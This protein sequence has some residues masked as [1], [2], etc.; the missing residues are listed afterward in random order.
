MKTYDAAETIQATFMDNARE[1]VD[2]FLKDGSGQK[3]WSAA[4]LMVA[5][6]ENALVVNDP[7]I[8]VR[9]MRNA[10]PIRVTCTR[11][12]FALRWTRIAALP[13]RSKI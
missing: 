11:I 3:L 2:S 7:E 5:N 13:D 8:G 6:V 12:Q 1:F 10:K 4:Q 9:L